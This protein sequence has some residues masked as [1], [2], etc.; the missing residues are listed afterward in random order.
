VETGALTDGRA[1]A[2]TLVA[3][4]RRTLAIEAIIIYLAAEFEGI[5]DIWQD[6]SNW[7]KERNWRIASKEPCF[8]LVTVGSGASRVGCA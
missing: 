1:A 4:G 5:E 8:V 7:R 3:A 2:A 6:R